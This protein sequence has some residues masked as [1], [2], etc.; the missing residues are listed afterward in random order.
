M[1]VPVTVDTTPLGD[2]VEHALKAEIISGRLAP[3]QRISH[4]E[5]A[6]KWNVSYTPV[7]DAIRHLESQG[8]VKVLP[9]RGVFVTEL[10]ATTFQDIFEV[11]IA[12]EVLAAKSATVQAPA[13]ELE[14]VLRS[15][16]EAEAT[17]QQTGD[18]SLLVERDYMVHDLLMRHCS[19][20]KVIEIMQ[21][22]RDLVD[23]AQATIVS[24]NPAAYATTVREHMRIVEA[25]LARDVQCAQHEIEMHLQG[26][27][28]R[29]LAS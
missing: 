6:A 26:A 25:M 7:R 9:R 13:A 1:V 5:L 2:Q 3:G 29:Y 12:L 21:G 4:E 19:N 27:L 11:R 20:A 16:Q 23:W 28:A 8:F 15:Y 18:S 17:Y 22:L 14:R 10:D 24:R